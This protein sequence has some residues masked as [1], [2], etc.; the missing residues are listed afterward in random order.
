MDAWLAIDAY[1]WN[2]VPI[3][4][5]RSEEQ[6]GYYFGIDSFGHVGL[7]LAVDGQWWTLFFKG[8]GPVERWSQV[9]GTYDPA[10]GMAIYLNGK[11]V[12]EPRCKAP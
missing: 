6:S 4:D 1:P 9:A 12:G 8:P 3:V 2:W 7:M 11:P 10:K 5:H